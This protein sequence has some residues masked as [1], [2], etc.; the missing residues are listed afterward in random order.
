MAVFE[1]HDHVGRA[2]GFE[3][4]QYPDDIVVFELTK[5]LRLFQELLQAPAQVVESGFIDIGAWLDGALERSGVAPFAEVTFEAL[6]HAWTK[7]DEVLG[8]ER[9]DRLRAFKAQVDPKGLLNPRKVIGNGLFGTAM[10]LAGA[11]EPLIRPFGNAV[12]TMVGERPTEPVRDIPPDVAWYAYS[13]S[14]CGY[15]V[16]ECD[17][18]YGRGWES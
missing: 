2:I 6:S 3:K 13:C 14:Q 17:Q 10:G 9:A 15:C 7:A 16:D 12:I 4:A 18:F 8:K 5:C 11:F 1:F